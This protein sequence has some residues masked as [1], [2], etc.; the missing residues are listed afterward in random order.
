MMEIHGF[1]NVYKDCKVRI[2]VDTEGL[3]VLGHTMTKITY[4]DHVGS[5]HFSINLNLETR[6][7]PA[8]EAM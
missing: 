1:W 8:I 2:K 4:A 7:T 6:D 3:G 5:S